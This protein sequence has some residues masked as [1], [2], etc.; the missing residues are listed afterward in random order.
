[1]LDRFTK[2]MQCGITKKFSPHVLML[3]ILAFCVPAPSQVPEIEWERI[4]SEAEFGRCV[5]QTLDGGY[6]IIGTSL[7]KTDANGNLV[8]QKP[9]SGSCI[10]Q[11]PDGGYII[12]GSTGANDYLIKVDALGNLLWQKTFGG[13]N[14]DR[15]VCVQLT[16][17]G[18]YIIV[19]T[20][21]P[22]KG[23]AEVY[24]IKT[25]ASGNL[26]W[27]RTFGGS[28][29]DEGLFVQQTLDGG[30]IIVGTTLSF[31]AGSR[32]VYLIRTDP[33]G[34]LLWQKT[35][36][37]NGYES[38]RTVH[39]TLDGGYVIGGSTTSFA[40]RFRDGYVVKTDPYGNLLWQETFTWGD[41]SY[42][43]YVKQTRDGGYIVVG[44]ARTYRPLDNVDIYI[45]KLDAHGNR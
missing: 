1:M 45:A 32:D 24:L 6:I 31:G 10:R 30:Y 13:N 41:E 44:M 20:T 18:G 11:A 2:K 28:N 15:H 4:F 26:L 19:G 14:Y 39:Q 27:H 37:G 33:Y 17:D 43:T 8:W 38:A 12:V 35:F 9:F 29:D 25:D 42:V 3:L 7:I 36:G 23:D 34:N 40:A 21:R 5:Q 16:S 22:S